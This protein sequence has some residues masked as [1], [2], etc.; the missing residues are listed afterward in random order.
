MGKEFVSHSGS[1]VV[2][3]KTNLTDAATQLAR[4]RDPVVARRP[5]RLDSSFLTK[6]IRT[7]C[8]RFPGEQS[9]NRQVAIAIRVSLLRFRSRRGQLWTALF[10]HR[11]NRGRRFLRLPVSRQSVSAIGCLPSPYEQV[12][13]L[14]TKDPRISPTRSVYG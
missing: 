11:A 14:G 3:A 9:E 8:G 2:L 13:L 7:G 6:G 10:A 4:G 12:L 5:V 1:R